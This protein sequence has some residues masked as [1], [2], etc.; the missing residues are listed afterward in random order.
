MAVRVLVVKKKHIDIPHTPN[1]GLTGMGYQTKRHF[2]DVKQRMD[3][4]VAQ[5]EDFEQDQYKHLPKQHFVDEH[6]HISTSKSS[7]STRITTPKL[8]VKPTSTHSRPKKATASKST[9]TK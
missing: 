7:S 5:Q 2:I 3:D 1:D 6:K 8:L 9:I 4:Y